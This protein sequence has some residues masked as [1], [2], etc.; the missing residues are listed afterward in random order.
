MTKTLLSIAAAALLATPAWALA[1]GSP[2]DPGKST[3]THERATTQAE[4]PGP[5]ATPA[6]ART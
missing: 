3:Q 2:T 1:D 4:P 6:P 5:Q